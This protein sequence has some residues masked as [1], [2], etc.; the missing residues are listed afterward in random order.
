MGLLGLVTGGHLPSGYG[1]LIFAAH[2]TEQVLAIG[3]ARVTGLKGESACLS[4][5]HVSSG[6]THCPACQVPAL[7]VPG[8]Q[9][10]T[11]ADHCLRT[12]R[13]R[14]RVLVMGRLT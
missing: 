9:S 2:F 3:Q 11:R 1:G 5:A 13:I 6:G 12:Q 14:K 4:P 7:W 10:S 8:I